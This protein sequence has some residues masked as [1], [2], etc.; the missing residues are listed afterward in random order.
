MK[1]SSFNARPPLHIWTLVLS[2]L[3]GL[4]FALNL[5]G[6]WQLLAPLVIGLLIGR[7]WALGLVTFFLALDFYVL[8]LFSATPLALDVDSLRW[9]F[10][11]WLFVACVAWVGVALGKAVAT[12]FQD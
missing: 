10:T 1:D 6:A 5:Y 12:V 2:V 3:I 8:P 11:L 9:D 4:G 7:W